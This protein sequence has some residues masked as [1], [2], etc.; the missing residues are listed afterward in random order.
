MRWSVRSPECVVA[1]DE[2][3]MGSANESEGAGA[4]GKV[5]RRSQQKSIGISTGLHR[6]KRN[7]PVCFAAHFSRHKLQ[8]HGKI[9]EEGVGGVAAAVRTRLSGADVQFGNAAWSALRTRDPGTSR[10]SSSRYFGISRLPSGVA[11]RFVR[12]HGSFV[13]SKRDSAPRA[14]AM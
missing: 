12:S 8:S 3:E 7:A 13:T 4:A 10:A 6:A 5:F 14:F 11:A 2:F 1:V 9:E